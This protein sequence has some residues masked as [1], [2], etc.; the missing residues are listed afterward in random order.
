[1]RRSVT[2]ATLCDPDPVRRRP[3]PTVAACHLGALAA[4]ALTGC[5]SAGVRGL[6][7]GAEAARSP[8]L[9]APP[10][11][12]V[13]RVGPHPDGLAA[14]PATQTFVVGERDPEALRLVDSRSGALRR[15]VTFVPHATDDVFILPT[16][17]APAAAIVLPHREAAAARGRVFVANARTGTVAVFARGRE[18]TRF[19][20]AAQPG[21]L[22]AADRGRLLAVVSRRERVLELYDP[23]TLKRVARAPAGVG[24]TTVA[25]EADRLYVADTLG[26]ALLVFR[27]RPQ[28]T[29]TRRVALPGS[30]YGLAVD[31]VRHRLWVTLTQ[32][33]ELVSLPADDRPR[34]LLRLPT[35]RQPDTVAVDSGLGT[36]AVAGRADGVLQL[37]GERQ[38]Y[39]LEHGVRGSVGAVV[40]RSA[41]SPG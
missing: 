38:A 20:V 4:A 11:G 27:V 9:A 31:P 8:A 30:P 28:L 33:N 36:V 29:L 2:R 41:R 10:A 7:P 6:P 37:V 1:M 26:G 16:R 5:G 35:V 12:R 32:R 24:P 34:P 22:A 25:A 19:R 40:H 17:S 21:G 15:R 18:T 14:E 39:P 3:S 13:V 23:R